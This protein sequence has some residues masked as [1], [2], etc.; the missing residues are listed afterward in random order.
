VIAG[1][2]ISLAD[3]LSQ[4]ELF[5]GTQQGHP[6]DLA[7]IENE[8]PLAGGGRGSKHQRFHADLRTNLDLAAAARGERG[9]GVG[10]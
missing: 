3:A 4:G 6:A 9:A 2:A 10:G 5:L 1:G 7:Q 8:S